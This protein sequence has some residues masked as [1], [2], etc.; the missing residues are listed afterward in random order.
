MAKA[1]RSNL[2]AASF[3]TRATPVTVGGTRTAD[4]RF[5]P[6]AMLEFSNDT[7]TDWRPAG[8]APHRGNRDSFTVKPEEE[9]R[10]PFQNLLYVN[11]GPLRAYVGKFRYGRITLGNGNTAVFLLKDLLAPPNDR[12]NTEEVK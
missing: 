11:A 4:G 5:W 8:P 1:I 2:P 6:D 10:S 7:E 12:S 9:I 3:S